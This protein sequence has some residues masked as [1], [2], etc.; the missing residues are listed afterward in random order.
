ML[1]PGVVI[2]AAGPRASE[3]ATMAGLDLPVEPRRRFSFLFTQKPQSQAL[4]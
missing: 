3:V 2:N 4:P 1:V